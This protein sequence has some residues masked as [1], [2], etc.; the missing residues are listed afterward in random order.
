[1]CAIR[2][3]RS[4][5]KVLKVLSLPLKP[6]MKTRRRV[7]LGIVAGA[8]AVAVGRWL[9]LAAWRGRNGRSLI[10]AGGRGMTF[11]W[12]R[13]CNVKDWVEVENVFGVGGMT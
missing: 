10:R 5:G 13:G 3:R 8:G 2:E 4:V 11:T 6:W 9:F 7:C 12:C 1:M